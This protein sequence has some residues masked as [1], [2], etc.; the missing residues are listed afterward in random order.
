MT[1]ASDAAPPSGPPSAPSGPASG[2]NAPK[3]PAAAGESATEP[4]GGSRPSPRRLARLAAILFFDGF[5]AAPGWMALVTA[6]LVV[7][8]VAATC[9]PLGYRLLADGALGG[10]TA[11]LAEGVA[12]VAVLLG[13]AWVLVGVGATEAMALSDRI[14]VYRTRRMIELIS[15]VPTLEHLERP[16]YLAQV[17]RLNSGRRQL[18]SAPR[19][20]LSNVS[21]VARI[22]ALLVLLGSVSPWLLLLP[23]TAVPPLVADRVAK[24]ITRKSED[25]MAADRRLAGMIFDISANAGAAGELRS[26]GLAPRLKSLHASLTGSLDRR[27]AREARAV[28]A[29]QSAGWLLYAAGLMGAIA[30]V[31]VR[32][33]DGALSLGTVLMTVSLIR[34]SRAQLA[35]SA[36]VSAGM[37][38]TLAVADRL[39]WLEDHHAAAVAAAGTAQAPARLRSAITI[40]DLS[41]TYPGTERSVLSSLSLTFPAGATVAIV[42]ENGSGKTT[43]V[44]LLLGMYTPTSGA[45]YVDDVPLASIAHDS[46]RERCTA[47]FQDFARFSLPAV[48]SVGVADLPSLDCEPLALA[49]LDRAGA[50]GLD[51]QLP[52]GL[53]TYVGGPYTGGHNLS[54]GQWQKL[55]LGRA[56]RAPDPLLV[57]LDEPT[58]SL[59]AHAEQALFDRYTSAAAEY[60]ARSGTVTLLVSHRFATV[61]TADLIVYLEEGHATEAGTHDELLA[62]GGRYAELFTL[63]AAAYR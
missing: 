12:V 24:K 34:R 36:S 49:A 25:E 6:M 10:N 62:R 46:W 50:A 16:D 14:A 53:S 42:G 21:S 31:A 37:I 51:A 4:E 23:V 40:R 11:E 56:M 63:Q 41:F 55:A 30:F 26:Y 2:S 48:E 1:T 59:D 33:S 58:A 20:I 45:V 17:E 43:L 57:V 47:A 19:Q 3:D 35:M 13:L 54:G 38:S 8:S 29:V 9:Y 18:A 52:E 60:A 32:A 5:R 61:R 7:G 15:G 27:A 44:K 22:I 39:L 28:L